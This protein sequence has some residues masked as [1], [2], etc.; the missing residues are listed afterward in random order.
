MIS[1]LSCVTVLRRCHNSLEPHRRRLIVALSWTLRSRRE[2]FQQQ[3]RG[4]RFLANAES[5]KAMKTET[6]ES[7]NEPISKRHKSSLKGTQIIIHTV[8]SSVACLSICILCVRSQ[9]RDVAR[10]VCI[11]A[12]ELRQFGISSDDYSIGDCK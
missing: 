5:R 12:H 9:Q 11:T 6:E 3:P 8:I 10:Q 7:R 2:S 4:E 1:S